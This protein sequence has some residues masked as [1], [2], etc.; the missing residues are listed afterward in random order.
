MLELFRYGAR[1]RLKGSVYLA[2]GV[3]LLAALVI[4]VFPSFQQ[5]IDIDRLLDAYP[6]PVLK[7][8]GIETMASL[9][10]FLA[11][12]LYAFAWV[13]LFGLYTAYAAAGIV[14]DAVEHD[15]MDLWLALPVRRRRLLLEQFLTLLVPILV[16]N[17]VTPIVVYAGSV[18]I[19][20]PLSVRDLAMVHALSVP[21]LLATGAIGLLLGVL[22]HRSAIA[23]RAALALVFG[24]FLLESL[25]ADT[26]LEWAGAASPTRYYPVNDI[27]IRGQ[28]DYVSAGILLG[29]TVVLVALAA[30]AF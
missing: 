25:V 15:R 23:E 20:D 29:A 9:E 4:W 22:V 6:E 28:Y 12:E 11:V 30:L 18:L 10:G 16:V 1:R 24:L 7:A 2:V 13:I 19:D 17:V 27:L 3:S 5:S 14:S 8:F 21:Y 26:D